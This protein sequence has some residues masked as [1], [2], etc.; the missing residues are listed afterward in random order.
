VEESLLHSP[1]SQFL[2]TLDLLVPDRRCGSAG[3]TTTSCPPADLDSECSNGSVGF[4]IVSRFPLTP[5]GAASLERDRGLGLVEVSFL[6]SVFEGEGIGLEKESFLLSVLEEEGFVFDGE[7]LLLSVSEGGAFGLDGG[8][9]LL[10]VS[11]GGGFGLEGGEESFL[12][13]VS[14]GVTGCGMEG[15]SVS[16]LLPVCVGR[17]RDGRYKGT[18]SAH[19]HTYL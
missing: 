10:F 6:F 9:F 3:F 17:T 4:T 15:G 13:T 18:E 5:A 1:L 12:I 8:S 16:F 14:E 19:T 2:Q 11:E 7:S